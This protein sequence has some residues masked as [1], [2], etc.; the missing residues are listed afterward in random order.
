MA[1]TYKLTPAD[2]RDIALRAL[3]SKSSLQNGY[4]KT[5]PTGY[6]T[7]QSTPS[8]NAVKDTEKDD[9]N[10]F[11]RTLST[12]GDL[13][14]NVITG[15]AKGLEG[16][17]DLGA[18]VVGA[19]GGLFSDDFQDS[20]KEHIS[21]DF[22]GEHIG[23]PLQEAFQ[24]SYLENGGFIEQVAGG[25]GQMLPAVAVSVLTGGAGAP[26]M[27]T[28]GAS[29]A[30]NSTEEAFNDG[31]GYYQGM[32]YGLASGATE[33]V[34]EKFGGF[35]PGGGL[36]ASGKALAGTTIG[37]ATKKGVGKLAKNFVDEGL[38]EVFSDAMN[39]A[40]KSIYKG[41]EAFSEYTDPEFYK[42][43]PETFV[44]GGTVGSVMTPAQNLVMSKKKSVKQMG[45]SKAL[46]ANE[47]MS[48]I[49]EVAGNFGA[50]ETK[51][52][53]YARAIDTSLDTMS[54]NMKKMTDDQRKNYLKSIERTPMSLAFDEAGNKIAVPV[55]SSVSSD[56][57][58]GSVRAVGGNIK[59]AVTKNKVSESAKTTK[60]TIERISN[61]NV[62][63]VVTDE[64]AS[65]QN[66][67]FDPDSGIFYV[68]NNGKFTKDFTEKMTAIH[69]VMHSAEGT[70]E[71]NDTVKA[72]HELVDSSPEVAKSVMQ[73]ADNTAEQY[74]NKNAS[75]TENDYVISTEIN[76]D[77]MGKL[78]GS[79]E[80]ISRL[81]LRNEGLVKKLYG[82][83]TTAHDKAT[84]KEV[85]RALKKICDTFGKAIDKS[86]GGL[87]LSS[88]RE[89]EKEELLEEYKAAK[90]EYL[91]LPESERAA[92]LEE[93][94]YTAE[95]F[96]DDVLEDNDTSEIVNNERA[97]I[98]YPTFSQADISRNMETLA[99]MD[100]VATIDASKLE[101]T[102]KS[103]KDMFADYFESLGNSIYSDV[104]GDI[105]LKNSSVKSEI[106]HGIT[107]EKIASI[108]AIPAVIEAGEV[109]FFKVKPKTDVERI[110]VAA[111]IKIGIDDYYMGVMLQRD[112][113]NQ[114]LYLHNVVA[115]N[116]KEETTISSQDY[117]L[118]NWSDEDD[119]RL[120][121][122]SI[123]QKAINVK[124]EKQKN[125]KEPLENSSERA[126]NG[127][128]SNMRSS[129]SKV[130][131][132]QNL[133]Y[134]KETNNSDIGV[135][136]YGQENS[137]YSQ[138]LGRQGDFWRESRDGNGI[139]QQGN[140]SEE[141]YRS[142]GV[143]QTHKGGYGKKRAGHSGWF[144]RKQLRLG[145]GFL[146]EVQRKLL[147][148]TDSA[149]RQLSEELQR[150]LANTVLK[151]EDGTVL[152]LYHWTN[153]QFEKF[154]VSK[155][156]GFHFGTLE[157]ANNRR[158]QVE[159]KNPIDTTIYKEVYVNIKNPVLVN[160]DPMSW[161]ALPSSH[162]AYQFGALT[163]EQLSTL[164]TFEGY[165]RGEY[166][167]PALI[168]L[169]R[170]LAENGYDGII[171]SNDF[172]GDLSVIAFYPEQII[173]VA[174]NGIDV[175]SDEI[176]QKNNE[177]DNM[178]FSKIKVPTAAYVHKHYAEWQKLKVYEKEDAEKMV[179]TVLINVIS[180]NEIFA[181]MSGASR[182][183]AQRLLQDRL[184]SA[185]TKAD[186]QK[187][188][189]DAADY[190]MSKTIATDWMNEEGMKDEIE[191]CSGIVAIM[192]P[193]TNNIDL[194]AIKGEIK[195]RYDTKSTSIYSRW[196]SKKSRW[197]ADAIA[198][199]LRE[200][201]IN[202]EGDNEADIFFSIADMYDNAKTTINKS[203]QEYLAKNLG[204]DEYK[205]LKADIVKKLL[206]MKSELG[207]DSNLAV[208]SRKYGKNLKDAVRAVAY[209]KAQ[210]SVV[211][212][213]EEFKKV[214]DG[215]FRN[216]S[217][218]DQSD[219]FDGSVNELKK[220]T[221]GGL[222]SVKGT[223]KAIR[224]LYT[225]YRHKDNPIVREDECKAE[226][227]EKMANI[228]NG[229]IIHDGKL[230]NVKAVLEPYKRRI[231]LDKSS[232]D[233][234]KEKYS[235]IKSD[236]MPT[237]GSVWSIW[238]AKK[239]YEGISVKE[240]A[241]E[242]SQKGITLEGND[243]EMLFQIS[244][245]YHNGESGFSAQQ[246]QE[247][248]DVV[249][250][251]RHFIENFNKV[252]N[253]K[254]YIDAIPLATEYI[255][256]M[257]EN[258]DVKVGWL[259]K[260]FSGRYGEGFLR[261]LSLAKKADMYD[262]G[263]FTNMHAQ[264]REGLLESFNYE[265]EMT[266]AVAKFAEKNKKYFKALP[267]R[268]IKYDG[269][270]IPIDAAMSLYMTM[271]REQAQEGLAKSG[272][273]Y[274]DG[275]KEIEVS[276]YTAKDVKSP[277][278][279]LIATQ[280]KQKEL[281]DQFSEK[282][283]EF[284]A[285]AEEIFNKHCKKLKHD[286]DMRTKGFSNTVD[287]Y[288]YPI[289]REFVAK[290]IDSDFEDLI[291]R[292]SNASFNKNTVR[293]AK[294]QLCIMPLTDVLRR[295][296]RG[297]AQ[298]AAL[299]PVIRNYDVLYNLDIGGNANVPNSIAKVS[300]DTWA[301]GNDYMK[302]LLADMQ[303]LTKE[304]NP[305]LSVITG[306]YASY[307]LGANPK[308]WCTQLSSLFAATSEL[309]YDCVIK[310]VFS[311]ISSKD[312]DEYCTLAKLRNANNDAYLA[313]ANANKP[314]LFE[315][316]SKPGE[317]IKNISD[318]LM[319]PIG[320]VDRFVIKRLFAA[321]QVQI[322]KNEG[323]KVG[324]KENKVKAGELLEKV[325]FNT[326]QNSFATER[327][328]AMR[329]GF[330][331]KAVTMFSADSMNVLGQWVDAH[332]ECVVLKN[333]IKKETDSTK[334]KALE[335]RLKAAKKKAAKS[336]NALILSAA[337]MALLAVVFNRYIYGR[338]PEEDESFIGEFTAAGVG[339]ILG[340]LP[341][342]RDAYTRIFEGYE[343]SDYA[344]SM[345]NDVLDAATNIKDLLPKL[346]DG[347]ADSREGAR[348]VRNLIYSAGQVSGMPTRNI[349]NV[350]RGITKWFS[351]ELTYK[352]DDSFY[353][354]SYNSDLEKAI[355]NDDDDMIATITGLM[356]DENI[357]GIEDSAS[358]KALDSLVEKG[359]KV[360]PSSAPQKLVIDGE[361]KALTSAQ[362][363]SFERV[364]S[365][366]NEALARLVRMSQFSSAED[367]VKAK[368]VN[369]IYDVY[370]DLALQEIIGEE[371]NDK[372]V[373]FA[374][375]LDIEKLA[376]I[377]SMARSI[378]ADTDKNGKT[379]SG[380]KKAKVQQ[381]VNSLQLSAA[382][383]YMIM[384]YLGYT[385][386]KGESQVKSYINRLNLSKAEKQK[387]FEYSGYAS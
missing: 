235:V 186:E 325:I 285:I 373:L 326:Q 94:G 43:L 92:W 271:K 24:Y 172:E 344:Y 193:W 379:V 358:R 281:Y 106:R 310:G 207:R 52:A 244:E 140:G 83:F 298:Y 305:F 318:V 197:T 238:G 266:L 165:H 215:K 280:M 71:Y 98:K 206:D 278:E 95:D 369:F 333:K 129:Y 12:I 96:N 116:T 189:E 175:N 14:G 148:S 138:V 35:I 160:G 77:A 33:M 55:D 117:S 26:A 162:K 76:A 223:R 264:F 75:K 103:P 49:N 307:Q 308:T 339:N 247:L 25:F 19:V 121:I 301:N 372:D 183:Q 112:K 57:M 350:S 63:V 164:E 177:N 84:S 163:K 46:K 258:A 59:Y 108:E 100:A 334:I 261:P 364:Y 309:D 237:F 346:F 208:V 286:V 82:Y 182:K 31:A 65:G 115:L 352:I 159:K 45:G 28:M 251:F 212:Q 48:Y 387:L 381:L 114:R 270:D 204:E 158:K 322:E 36:S 32:G 29:A 217:T 231:V 3:A 353:K 79:E 41:K 254:K 181:E 174:E 361:E 240:V 294:G 338:E 239:G 265:H 367:K 200:L 50:D 260:L 110:V 340:G 362:R 263:F 142:L 154:T 214:A 170:M 275:K 218:F 227:V 255:N 221:R 120:F 132:A 287:G 383:K 365:I 269:K 80:Y 88:I 109:I 321:C 143:L 34:A 201:G 134:D 225:W 203:Y 226:I 302:K 139:R 216:A 152:S 319:V 288:Y 222:I 68:N 211:Y 378:T 289:K 236:E 15:A 205:R 58:S 85:R 78:L 70:K 16:I 30:G 195:H 38:E 127:E 190:I 363:K 233:E 147:K 220:I 126:N 337:F 313:E 317:V 86:V 184:N 268:R 62:S 279:L 51:N 187:A 210:A 224:D 180:D 282:D 357:G 327:S 44:V 232:Y 324:T 90:E 130:D 173:T 249:A 5:A 178:R 250:Y 149:G 144:E 39:P 276:A 42:Q 105:A 8:V 89:K 73:G 135:D 125:A 273:F 123:L 157:A 93:N 370:Y 296:V 374:E 314:G 118:T 99:D 188:A 119:S 219:L 202:I 64:L 295:H 185:V 272:F 241:E 13:V 9:A 137:E 246:L 131:K 196:S 306:S 113:V 166:N 230:V 242:L 343:A 124:A 354:Q 69:E 320:K 257:I 256:K 179:D 122:T 316:R 171:Y 292:A 368:A 1:S 104:F 61:N 341:L 252:W 194:S 81:A 262:D 328:A 277:E 176:V 355:E 74:Y 23:T 169:R 101:K 386:V 248:A 6:Q 54:E 199:E 290:S 315:T 7:A 311:G 4:K 304:Y 198:G 37:E 329:G 10:F 243:A 336:R 380:S 342:W 376:I 323:L 375:A 141:I 22:A 332:C 27:L 153:A 360:I 102:G 299:A 47:A 259:N 229:N 209:A 191:R 97:S 56:A 330:L 356:L 303:G 18:S 167:S 66:A 156:I 284:I 377:I 128:N 150:T 20:V 155:D 168:E 2:R 349:Y 359:H 312:V 335:E 107:A 151:D 366:S 253:G 283:R 40:L 111:P 300:K 91:S 371:L 274:K 245:M 87:K 228:A 331:G 11:V 213:V 60:E 145:I 146:R 347:T 161:R 351:P 293:G 382:E 136:E 345:L 291:G 53:R 21:Y 192:K 133:G 72:L 385:N 17:Y 267:S 67:S 234:L 297:V 384:G 348:A